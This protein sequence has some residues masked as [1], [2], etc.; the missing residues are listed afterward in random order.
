MRTRLPMLRW[1]ALPALVLAASLL[2]VRSVSSAPLRQ[3]LT[4]TTAGFVDKF[5]QS[6]PGCPGCNGVYDAEDRTE[7]ETNPS[8]WHFSIFGASLLSGAMC[9]S[10]SSAASSTGMPTGKLEVSIA[11]K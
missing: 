5:P 1:F 6:D 7:A 4:I 11:I 10:T 2:Q 3:T 8:S 9:L